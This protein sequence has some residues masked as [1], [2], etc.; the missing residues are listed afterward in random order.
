MSPGPAGPT[1]PAILTVV[2]D[3]HHRHME[4]HCERA[5][6]L[7]HAVRRLGE[8]GLGLDGYN[9]QQGNC[10]VS[11]VDTVCIIMNEIAA[12]LAQADAAIKVN[13]SPATWIPRPGHASI[14]N[15]HDAGVHRDQAEIR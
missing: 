4:R 12:C 13:S 9:K 2:I 1:G 14:S 11:C 6:L 3:V 10:I 7:E 8:L 5:W 15:G